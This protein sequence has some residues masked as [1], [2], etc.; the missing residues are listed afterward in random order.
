MTIEYSSGSQRFQ[1]SD[2]LRTVHA[3]GNDYG[4]LAGNPGE[5]HIRFRGG[6]AAGLSS[7]NAHVRFEMVDG[8]LHNCPYFVEGIPFIG[9]PLDAGE[10]SEVHV[11]VSISGASLF[12]GAAW[13]RAVTYP[14]SFYHVDFWAYPFVPV[15]TSFF[16]AVPCIFHGEA[17]VSGAGG[18]AVNVVSDL[19]KGT[20]ISW[21][22]RNQGF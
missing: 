7:G 8:T 1:T 9:I 3:V 4:K 2:I 18:I 15:R 21:I 20:F 6:V 12:C 22:I 14:F 19:F 13:F 11:V 16:M 17:A 5:K 10:H